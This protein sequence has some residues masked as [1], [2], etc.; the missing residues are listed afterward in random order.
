MS[1]SKHLAWLPNTF[2]RSLYVWQSISEYEK[3]VTICQ[4]L[5]VAR[6]IQTVWSEVYHTHST[7]VDHPNI[8]RQMVASDHGHYLTTLDIAHQP[9]PTDEEVRS[10]IYTIELGSPLDKE[11]TIQWLIDNGYEHEQDYQ[12][13]SYHMKGDTIHIITGIQEHIR[14][15]L[16][17]NQV[18]EIT[19]EHEW[20]M[21]QK[22]SIQIGKH[23]IRRVDQEWEQ[24]HPFSTEI[25]NIMSESQYFFLGVDFSETYDQL[26][27]LP[28][29]AVFL[30]DLPHDQNTHIP[31]QSLHIDNLQ[32]FSDCLDKH[33]QNITIYTKNTKP[34]HTFI[35]QN[36]DQTIDI[37]SLSRSA[38]ESF[39]IEWGWGGN[40]NTEKKYFIWDD[41]LGP[42][43]IKKRSRIRKKQRL[44]L[45]VQIKPGDYVVHLY[46]GVGIFRDCIKKDLSGVIREYLEIEYADQDKL[47]VPIEEVHR[48]SKYIGNQN[49]TLT[50]LGKLEWKKTLAKTQKEVEDIAEQLVHDHAQR[51]LTSGHDFATYENMESAFTEAFPY[52]HTP[53]QVKAIEEI[54][55][56]MSTP[57]SMDRLLSGDVGFGK[58]EVAFH[59]IYRS[60]L[61]AKQTLLIAPLVVLAFEHYDACMQRFQKFWVKVDILTRLSTT[62]EI[63]QTLHRL[64]HGEVHLVV[65][66]HRLLSDDIECFNLG[67]IVVDEEHKFWV[68]D[69]ERILHMKTGVDTLSLSATPIPRS[70][71]LA[72]G[73]VKKFSILTT[74]PRWKEP[75]KTIVTPY[76]PDTINK[77]IGAEIER[78]GKV[79]YVY[80]RVRTIQSMKQNLEKIL[81]K[82]AHIIITHG[83]MSGIELEDNIME[84]KTGAY[85]ILLTTTVIENGIN[86][87]D[88]NTII[89]HD[90]NQ[91]WLAQLH[92]LRGRVGRG[93]IPGYCYL[94]Y[95]KKE[96]SD[97]SR[98]RLVTIANNAH[99]GAGFEI[100]M[101]DMQLRGVGEVLGVKQSGKTI[102]V[103]I[104]FYLKLLE[105]KVE[106]LQDGKKETPPECKIDLGIS[107]FVADEFFH[108]H[109]DKIHFYRHLETID[110]LEELQ[111]LYDTTVQD[112]ESIPIELENLFLLSR[113]RILFRSWWVKHVKKSL[114]NYV[115]IFQENNPQ[116]LLRKFLNADLQT[117]VVLASVQRATLKEQHFSSSIGLLEYFL[118]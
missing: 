55:D 42:L 58:T 89:I 92:Q 22:K 77:A 64:K 25:F 18:D 53:D 44:D 6:R 29:S 86:F 60:F 11:S 16:F 118:G 45:L 59:A 39:V 43:F 30:N 46:H 34:L 91:F 65:G 61:N 75:I 8:F 38:S 95:S 50:R 26:T 101:R 28:L 109:I 73:G 90:A 33:S 79:F 47:F 15:S 27:A 37:V 40:S 106:E 63:N 105:Q 114:G 110:T 94:M 36:V 56:D 48:V 83:Q 41:L 78:G 97:E 96:L 2:G 14:V 80:N 108:S 76:D 3:T 62:K 19:V 51:Q 72:L 116:E 67:L 107:Y 5:Q 66:T 100:A 113:A 103:G 20:A 115:F 68:K 71:N 54:Y 102:D 21:H 57:Q 70:L 111:E 117:H 104:S 23:F 69:K 13:W 4:S 52:P 10:W 87:L 35:S 112:T 99:L 49:P 12:K 74:P 88:T 93:N 9:I 7:I 98:E 24:V 1:R 81:G 82:K 17:G 84:F 32:D 85:N 31:Y